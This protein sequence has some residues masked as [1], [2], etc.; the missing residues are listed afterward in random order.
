MQMSTCPQRTSSSVLLLLLLL[1]LLL[2]LLLVLRE[3]HSL[4][5]PV[6]LLRSASDVRTGTQERGT[7]QCTSA[8]ACPASRYVLSS[9][10]RR[11]QR[12]RVRHPVPSVL[13]G[14]MPLCLSP[15]ASLCMGGGA[16]YGSTWARNVIQHKRNTHPHTNTTACANSPRKPTG[17]RPRA[18]RSWG[19]QAPVSGEGSR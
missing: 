1:L 3:I 2:S 6:L 19:A 7:R 13:L 10:M 16:I 18:G 12:T 14:V 5:L 17:R 15:L 8:R 4:L 11:L 9:L